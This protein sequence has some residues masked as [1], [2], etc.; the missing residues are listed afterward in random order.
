MLRIVFLFVFIS[1]SSFS[2][3]AEIDSFQICLKKPVKNDTMRVFQFNELAWLYLDVDLDSS[4]DFNRKALQF[5]QKIRYF[6]GEMDALNT[7]GIIYRTENQALKAIAIYEQIIKLRKSRKEE[8][9]L[10]GPYSNLG[11]VYY[12]NGEY[13][14]AITN[15][16]IALDLTKKHK[17]I[18]DI[19]MI[20][21]NLGSCFIGLGLYDKAIYFYSAALKNNKKTNQTENDGL[22]YLNLA[23]IYDAKGLFSKGAE[24]SK[25]AIQPLQKTGNIRKLSLVYF[26]LV[27]ESKECNKVVEAKFYLRKLEELSEEL[28][29]HETWASYFQVKAN[30]M[31]ILAQNEQALLAIIKSISFVE[32]SNDPVQL[33]ELYM[34]LAECELILNKPNNA[35]SACDKANTFFARQENVTGRIRC[36]KTY[37]EIYKQIGNSALALDYIL[38]SSELEESE[39]SKNVDAQ[40][41]ALNALNNLE[42]KEKDLELSKQKNEKIELQNSRQGNIIFAGTIISLLV[43]I[44]LFLSIRSSS[45]RKKANSLLSEQK[46]EIEDQKRLVDEKQLDILSSIHYGKRI[47]NTLLAQK[48]NIEQNTQDFALLFKPKDIVSGDFY[49]SSETYEYFFLAVCDSTGHGVPGAFM[50]ILNITY[51]SEAINELKLT[52]PHLVLNHVRNRLISYLSHDGAQDGMDGVLFCLNKKTLQLNYA[53]AY[54]SPIFIRN[55]ELIFG[56]A[57]RMPIGKGENTK[58]F[59]LQT[60]QLQKGDT[61]YAF[62]D[63]FPDQFGEETGKKFK[64][65]NLN[66]LLLEISNENGD[67][68]SLLL[69][70]AFEKWKGNTEQIDDVT[71]LGFKV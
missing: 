5:A 4:K 53:A 62:T 65:K 21:G 48:K 18:E 61:V 43:L 2:Q 46:Q 51:L 6:N 19:S 66:N 33:A 15:Y 54:N 71:V 52:E 13:V 45:N 68:Q 60:F 27:T 16:D 7:K 32:D 31:L 28:D 9:K 20:Y 24:N 3:T 22:V 56:E 10:I 70:D 29:E 12:E 34:T 37:S 39:T 63:G 50:S 44:L 67:K 49:W 59:S 8:I 57:D 11:S 36:L 17:K 58:D 38:K 47:Q 23:T 64:S 55:N 30:L 26:N 1:F 14:K 35:L 69:D 41:S 42:R 25:L 40:I